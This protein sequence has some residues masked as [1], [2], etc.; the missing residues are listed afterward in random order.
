MFLESF[1]SSSLTSKLKNEK[2]LSQEKT[3]QVLLVEA[4]NHSFQVNDLHTA[5]VSSMNLIAE[6]CDAHCELSVHINQTNFED[7]S[8]NS[9]SILNY[10]FLKPIIVNKEEVGK[11]KLS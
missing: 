5:L 4:I 7:Q 9:T 1:L 2:K 10:E 6:N 11:L 8:S 3:N